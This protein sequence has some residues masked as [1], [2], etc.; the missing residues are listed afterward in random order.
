MKNCDTSAFQLAAFI[1][2]MVALFIVVVF[3]EKIYHEVRRH[4]SQDARAG[5]GRE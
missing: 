3:V 4:S 5:E 2:E 1:A